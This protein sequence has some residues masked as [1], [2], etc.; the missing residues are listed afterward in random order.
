MVCDDVQA[1]L[2]PY[3]DGEL[4][5]AH[6]L[7]VER[8]LP[9]CPRCAA[10]LAQ[11]QGLRKALRRDLAYHRAPDELRARGAA[12]LALP[13][14]A[15][16]SRPARG[17][18]ARR[19]WWAAMAAGLALGMVL[20]GS[21][22]GYLAWRQAQDRG[23]DARPA[24]HPRALP[25]GHLRDV[26]TSDRHEVKPWFDGRVAYAPPVKDLGSAGFPLLGG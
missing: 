17:G 1:L 13:A 19:P 14:P 23:A 5:A 4:D 18:L 11:L 7:D 8:H 24:R 22:T 12:S 16:P 9:A 25:P 3:V 2:D 15:A 26:P 21:G 6:A 20:G 10:D